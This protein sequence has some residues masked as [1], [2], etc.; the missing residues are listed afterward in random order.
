MSFQ[1]CFPCSPCSQLIPDLISSPAPSLTNLWSQQDLSLHPAS[2]PL[3]LCF[4][5]P[6]IPAFPLGGCALPLHPQ[7]LPPALCPSPSRKSSQNRVGQLP[8]LFAPHQPIPVPFPKL[9][10]QQELWG[11]SCFAFIVS[12]HEPAQMAGSALQVGCAQKVHSC[13][14]AEPQGRLLLKKEIPLN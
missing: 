12:E 3:T 13:T 8:P 2:Q 1:L 9:L 14:G 7:Q 10:A 6:F 4:S 11:K 5:K